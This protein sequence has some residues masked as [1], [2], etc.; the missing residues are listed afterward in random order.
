[1][2]KKQRVYLTA[3]VLEVA[4]QNPGSEILLA[5]GR[6][7]SH[8]YVARLIAQIEEMNAGFEI[9]WSVE[10]THRHTNPVTGRVSETYLGRVYLRWTEQAA[11]A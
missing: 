2:M 3:E 6:R 8:W 1:M 9:G 4:R 7:V 10:A 5:D 11:A